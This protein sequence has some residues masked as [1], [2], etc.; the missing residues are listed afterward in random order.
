M[1]AKIPVLGNQPPGLGVMQ[2]KEN[3]GD[4]MAVSVKAGD[5]NFCFSN[6]LELEKGRSGDLGEELL[7]T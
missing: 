7:C 3:V 6:R 4:P 1:G 5:F 2:K